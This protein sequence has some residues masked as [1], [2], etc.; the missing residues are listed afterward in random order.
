MRS[1]TDRMMR[2]DWR[3]VGEALLIGRAE[4]L[5]EKTGKLNSKRFGEWCQSNGIGSLP[6][7]DRAAAMWLAETWDKVVAAVTA[8]NITQHSPKHIK[9]AF[10]K[11][12]ALDEQTALKAMKFYHMADA[13]SA[14]CSPASAGPISILTVEIDGAPWFVAADICRVLGR[15]NPTMALR[16][17]DSDEQ[18]LIRNEGQGRGG[19][20]SWKAINESGLY[21][22]VVRSTKP[23]VRKFQDW[24]TREVLPAIRK[25]GAYVMGEEGKPSGTLG[26]SLQRPHHCP[27][28]M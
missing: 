10:L 19:A 5:S 21:R 16:A 28:P 12:T 15:T 14:S 26:D 4:C 20:P 27:L 23:E 8:G 22:M 3:L 17:L 24:V 18:T 7:A 6:R 13:E 1:A 9:A 2:E 25:G 11:V